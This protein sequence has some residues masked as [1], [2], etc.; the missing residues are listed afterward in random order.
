MPLESWELKYCLDND[1]TRFAWADTNNGKGVVWWMKDEFGNEAW[2]DFKNVQFLRYLITDV[3][4]DAT[5]DVVGTYGI[6][7]NTVNVDITD[8]LWCYT[9]NGI[10]Y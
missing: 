8:N 10:D 7:T 4:G 3:D 2:Y 5:H 1:K 9:F 6:Q